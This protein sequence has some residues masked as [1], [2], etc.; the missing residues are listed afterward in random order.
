MSNKNLYEDEL[1]KV[2]AF[3]KQIV[4]D[5]PYFE[6]EIY[7]SEQEICDL[8][9]R[10]RLEPNIE[11]NEL[12][13]LA[14]E[15]Q[16]ALIRRGLNKDNKQMAQPLYEWVIK[17]QKTLEQLSQVLGDLRK[18]AKAQRERVYLPRNRYN[19]EILKDLMLSE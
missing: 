14:H 17:N 8:Q 12:C 9:H 13:D 6:S 2:I 5:V 7:S 1:V 3:F 4:S 11:E 19:E 18:I 16:K 15:L 10:I